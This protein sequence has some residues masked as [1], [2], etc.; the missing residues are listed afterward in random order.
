MDDMGTPGPNHPANRGL[1]DKRTEDQFSN[2]LDL[3]A[4]RV[5]KE[6]T[7]VARPVPVEAKAFASMDKHWESGIRDE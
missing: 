7:G 4:S 1:K 6:R 2:V 3:N 5:M